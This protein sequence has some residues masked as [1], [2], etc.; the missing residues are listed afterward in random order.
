MKMIKYGASKDALREFCRISP[1]AWSHLVFTGRYSF[2][3]NDGQIDIALL[4]EKL[5]EILREKFVSDKIKVK[6]TEHA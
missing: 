1:I 4:V 3:K 5:E 2:V 6:E